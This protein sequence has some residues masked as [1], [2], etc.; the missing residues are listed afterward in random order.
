MRNTSA[1]PVWT[2]HLQTIYLVQPFR[3]EVTERP[4]PKPAPR[5]KLPSLGASL[6]GGKELVA[7]GERS[8]DRPGAPE[9]HECGKVGALLVEHRQTPASISSSWAVDSLTEF[10]KLS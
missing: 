8:P 1:S 9:D 3:D 5:T 4:L 7:N 2:R 10:V 6:N